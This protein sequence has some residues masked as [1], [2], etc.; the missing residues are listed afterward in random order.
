MTRG[1]GYQWSAPVE[2]A[3][4]RSGSINQ[5]IAVIANNFRRG[6]IDIQSGWLDVA[7][8]CS[9]MRLRIRLLEFFVQPARRLAVRQTAIGI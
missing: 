1:Y 3:V 8:Q 2:H 9:R 5:Q 7:V 6:G 4:Q